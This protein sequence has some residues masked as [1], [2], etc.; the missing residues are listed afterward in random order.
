MCIHKIWVHVIDTRIPGSIGYN[1]FFVAFS[2]AHTSRDQRDGIE[3]PACRTLD[4][5]QLRHIVDPCDILPEYVEPIVEFDLMV[6]LHKHQHKQTEHRN[7]TNDGGHP[8]VGHT[9]VVAD[10]GQSGGHEC[11]D[12]EREGECEEAEEE[13]DAAA[14]GRE[15]DAPEAR[16]EV[17]EEIDALLIVDHVG[18]EGDRVQREEA[19][20]ATIDV[21]EEATDATV[22]REAVGDGEDAHRRALHVHGTCLTAIAGTAIGEARDIGH[23]PSFG[24]LEEADE[25]D[26]HEEREDDGMGTEELVKVSDTTTR[27]V[28]LPQNRTIR[29]CQALG[30]HIGSKR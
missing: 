28:D 11:H 13:R 23:N 2:G 14:Q 1:A 6:V 27:H 9:P 17:V 8:D 18:R 10:R 5:P 29:W 22:E 20:I 3:S 30:G 7:T 16:T 24:R 15:H 21:E 25:I 12:R 19:A 26:G 4:R